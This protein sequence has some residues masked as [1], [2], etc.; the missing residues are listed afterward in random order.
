MDKENETQAKDII[1]KYARR[2]HIPLEQINYKITESSEHQLLQGRWKVDIK[3]F[4][5]ALLKIAYEFSV[6]QIPSYFDD[7]NAINISKILLKGDDKE[8]ESQI[9]MVGHGFEEELLALLK[10]FL[11]FGAEHHY[12]ILV[13]N[14]VGLMCFIRLFDTFT[15]GF[16]MSE[17][18]GYLDNN[19][20]IGH[21][22]TINRKFEAFNSTDM[23]TRIYGPIVF[24]FEYFFKTK[25]ELTEFEILIN[26]PAFSFYGYEEGIPLFDQQCQVKYART[27]LKS[28][29]TQLVVRA[30]QISWENIIVELEMDELLYVKILPSNK[31]VQISAIREIMKR[32]DNM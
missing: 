25:P 17:H 21:N 3:E 24:S 16:I 22:D 14:G 26:D 13:D 30:S 11:N 19:M 32:K 23:I 18:K 1:A 27:T 29:Q 8:L 2:N 20:L 4:K 7:P 31:F 6:D 28:Q 12:I 5:I 9:T 10:P 15:L